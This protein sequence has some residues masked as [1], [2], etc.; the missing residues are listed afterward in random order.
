MLTKHLSSLRSLWCHQAH[1]SEE[2]AV[3]PSHGK[4]GG[5][6]KGATY[7]FFFFNNRLVVLVGRQ[8]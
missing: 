3:C 7:T 2:P 5:D 8:N 1:M 4:A 6:L